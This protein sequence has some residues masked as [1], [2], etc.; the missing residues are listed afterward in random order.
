MDKFVFTK[1][2]EPI[3]TADLPC[4][5][6]GKIVTVKVPFY[7]C[8]FCADCMKTQSYE[9]ADAPEFKEIWNERKK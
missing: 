7:G 2:G 6:C 5:N 1:K 3:E 8:I 9:T 4:Q